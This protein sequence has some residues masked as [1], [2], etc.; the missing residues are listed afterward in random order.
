MLLRLIEK[1]SNLIGK[2]FVSRVFNKWS[3]VYFVGP[4]V[5]H[6]GNAA[7][8]TLLGK[9]WPGVLWLGAGS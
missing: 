8:P 7:P 3:S 4:E 2:T 5:Q 9:W 6:S 1:S